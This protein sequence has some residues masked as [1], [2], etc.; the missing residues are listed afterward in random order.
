M[1]V[2]AHPYSE[3]YNISVMVCHLIFAFYYNILYVSSV[4]HTT[5]AVYDLYRG[6]KS[7]RGFP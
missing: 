3:H 5:G 2:P 7:G 1:P 6:G 4:L